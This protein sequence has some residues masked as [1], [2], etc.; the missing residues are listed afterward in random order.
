MGFVP[1]ENLEGK[2]DLI[3][4]SWKSGASLLKPWTWFLNLRLDRFLRILK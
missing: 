4:L 2:A 1:A 3:L